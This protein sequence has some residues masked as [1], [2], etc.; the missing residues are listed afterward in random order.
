MKM[1]GKKISDEIE[2]LT[3]SNHFQDYRDSFLEKVLGDASMDLRLHW[4]YRKSGYGRLRGVCCS[5]NHKLYYCAM[6]VSHQKNPGF[7]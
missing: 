6:I 2:L 1:H 4:I 3:W 7:L 5:E